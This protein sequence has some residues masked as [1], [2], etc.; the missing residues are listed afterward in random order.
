MSKAVST[1]I[2]EPLEI[3]KKRFLSDPDFLEHPSAILRWTERAALLI[4][5]TIANFSSAGKSF[6]IL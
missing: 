6:V 2:T 3:S 5:Y 4:C 1:S